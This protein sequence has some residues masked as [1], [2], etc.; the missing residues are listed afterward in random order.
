MGELTATEKRPFDPVLDMAENDLK[1][2][3]TFWTATRV[4]V[5]LGISK[6]DRRGRKAK[7]RPRI[8][9]VDPGS[10]G[11]MLRD[12]IARRL[13]V[14]RGHDPVLRAKP[15]FCARNGRQLSRDTVLG[16]VRLSLGKAGFSKEQ[17]ARYGTHSARIGGATR[18]FQLGATAEILK[19]MGGWSS[20]AYKEYVRV[21]QQDTM[22]FTRRMCS[23]A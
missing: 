11:E 23:E 4:V 13:N 15:L 12:L 9:P 3:P 10:P 17:A 1:F 2:Y 16:F 22:A 18:L 14:K 21:Q 6:A 19:R 7:L 8:L 5:Q 20:D